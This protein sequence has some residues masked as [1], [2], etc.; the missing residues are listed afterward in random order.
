G[1]YVMVVRP[2][3][4]Y[5]LHVEAEGFLPVDRELATT[6]PADGTR[7]MAMDLLM[8]RNDNTAGAIAP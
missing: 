4:K 8:V 1:R 7:E 2:G 6:S 3:A 5:T